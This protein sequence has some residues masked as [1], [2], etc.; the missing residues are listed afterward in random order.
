MTGAVF[1]SIDCDSALRE[2]CRLLTIAFERSQ[3]GGVAGLKRQ[4]VKL[5]HFRVA[6]HALD[7]EFVQ[8]FSLL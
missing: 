2:A 1:L 6:E 7:V 5:D 3:I 8:P 4:P